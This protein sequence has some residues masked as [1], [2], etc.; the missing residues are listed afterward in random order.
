V[1]YTLAFAL[2]LRTK[3]GK[4]SVRVTKYKNNEQYKHRRKTATEG[5]TMSQNNKEHRIHNSEHRIH[6]NIVKPV[7]PQMTTQYG[8]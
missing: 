8:A 2:Q 1:S 4:T 3:H 7:R 6:N 5:S